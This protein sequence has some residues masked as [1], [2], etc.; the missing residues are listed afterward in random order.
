ME[1]LYMCAWPKLWGLGVPFVYLI[2]NVVFLFSARRIWHHLHGRKSTF[3]TVLASLSALASW[4]ALGVVGGFVGVVGVGY[5]AWT[6]AI[7]LVAVATRIPVN[8]DQSQV[9]LDSD[10]TDTASAV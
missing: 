9:M 5:F 3:Y 8:S 4:I 6:A 7:T 1:F 2:V 10:G